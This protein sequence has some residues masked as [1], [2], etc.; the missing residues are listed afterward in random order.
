MTIH[1]VFEGVRHGIADGATE[2]ATGEQ[3]NAIGI[4]GRVHTSRG[5]E[6]IEGGG[7]NG[8]EYEA[9]Q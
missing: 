3:A 8:A 5:G 1:C 2:T 4:T 6:A 7:V 9:D